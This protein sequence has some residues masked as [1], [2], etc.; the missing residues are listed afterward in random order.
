MREI[1]RSLDPA[2]TWEI[3]FTEAEGGSYFRSERASHP[4]TPRRVEDIPAGAKESLEEICGIRA[5]SQI[6]IIPLAVRSVG[7]RSRKVISPNSVLALGDRAVGLWTEKPQPG[8]KLSIPLERVAAIEDVTILLYGR[9][10]FVPFGDRLTIR[11]NT[12]ARNEME[13]ALLE[14]RKRLA[15]SA[16][17][18]PFVEQWATELPFKWKILLGEPLVRLEKSSPVVFSFAA[19]HGRFRGEAERRQLLVLNPFELVYV[20][21]PTESTER[22]GVDSFVVPRSRITGVRMQ[23][24]SLEVSS[25][26]APILLSMAPSLREAAVRWVG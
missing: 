18:M 3:H 20:C 10:S 16:L 17:P 7:G 24:N 5:L 19:V 25:N 2:E 4:Y 21:D 23:E 14:L 1:V 11:Y 9:L 12:V 15:G 22:Y 13:P 26:G 8:V 6:F